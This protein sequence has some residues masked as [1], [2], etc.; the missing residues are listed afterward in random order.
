[1]YSYLDVLMHIPRI[2]QTTPISRRRSL[3]PGQSLVIR[4]GTECTQPRCFTYAIANGTAPTIV[5]HAYA[6]T[7]T[8]VMVI[9]VLFERISPLFTIFFP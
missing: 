2:A 7:I 9:Y 5:S 3:G 6:R 1:M 4:A 8:T